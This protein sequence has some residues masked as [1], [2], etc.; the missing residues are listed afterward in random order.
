MITSYVLHNQISASTR[1]AHVTA[2]APSPTA[3]AT[4]LVVPLRTSPAANTPGQV[5]STE[6]GSRSVRGQRSDFA[7]SAPVRMKPL[8]ST[9]TLGG[10]QS[11]LGWAPM[12]TK[13]AEQSSS[14]VLA[15]LDAA[16]PEVRDRLIALDGVDLNVANDLDL[17]MTLDAAGEI[18]GHAP[19]NVTSAKQQGGARSM[20]GQEHD[21]LAGRVAAPHHD[22]RGRSG[23]RGREP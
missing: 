11:V 8:E 17:G 2:S 10:S 12:N 5:V 3:N 14:R 13:T 9:A 22:A 6:Q 15:P 4:R 18:V 7:A 16:E 19:A 21:R 23:R 1:C 20:V